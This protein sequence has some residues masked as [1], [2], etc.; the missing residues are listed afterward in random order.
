[1]RLTSQCTPAPH[2]Y[3]TSVDEKGLSVPD[4]MRKFVEDPN[5]LKSLAM[6]KEARASSDSR[7]Q[8]SPHPNLLRSLILKQEERLLVVVRLDL[9]RN[10]CAKGALGSRG[11]L[12][13]L[14]WSCS[15]DMPSAG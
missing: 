1:M 12:L 10:Q 9:P 3:I 8:P 11:A 15:A 2:R 13:E 6:K 5:L 14:F 7:E 4:L